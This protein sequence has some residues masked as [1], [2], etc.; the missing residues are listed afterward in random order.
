MRR[1][2][3]DMVRFLISLLTVFCS[4]SQ[5]LELDEARHLWGRTGYA[6]TEYFVNHY[7]NIS[8]KEAVKYVLDN[9]Q[10]SEPVVEKPEF[11]DDGYMKI[12]YSNK[13]VNK[14]TKRKFRQANSVQ[15]KRK[16]TDWWHKELLKTRNRFQEKMVLFWHGHFTSDTAKVQAPLMYSQNQVFRK[17]ALGNFRDLFTDVFQNPAIHYYLDNNKNRANSLNENLAREMMELY[18]MGEGDHYTE[19]D[20]K[21]IARAISGL[22]PDYQS[23][24]M[25]VNQKKSGAGFNILLGDFQYYD[26]DGVIDKL[27]EQDK[28]AE[29]IT[30]KLWVEFI[31]YEVDESRLNEFSKI[32]KDSDYDLKTVISEI[33]NSDEFWDEK[34]R[35]ALIKSP[36]DMIASS[37]IFFDYSA[38]GSK[39][40]N[41]WMREAGIRLFR[42]PDVKG[43]RGGKN[44]INADLLLARNAMMQKLSK[45]ITEN[46]KNNNDYSSL[47][48]IVKKFA[49]PK[50]V[51]F[52]INETM[53]KKLLKLKRK[54]N[55]KSQFV[56]GHDNFNFK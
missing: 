37:S 56:L 28:T 43:W 29:F 45:K 51:I 23:K 38:V 40:I 30:R 49:E 48:N 39:K 34:N 16:I 25:K 33:L 12:L 55:K 22:Y 35:N 32:F 31:S 4:I 46:Y 26:L 1:R 11:D 54:I 27:L 36:F 13:K 6:N 5:A 42:P 3:Q 9:A 53:P 47:R 52:A 7:K 18:S 50:R 44:W 15:D 2:I 24:K 17:N 8:R 14:A 41:N 20:V 10:Y 19:S 21:T